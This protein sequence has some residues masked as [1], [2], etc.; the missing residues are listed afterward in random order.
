MKT[1]DT[2]GSADCCDASARNDRA[3]AAPG[4]AQNAVAQISTEEFPADAAA[5]RSAG[6][7]LLFATG[8]PVP[9]AALAAEAGIA[10]TDLDA[11]L[12]SVRDRGR[13]EIDEQ[14]CLVGIGGL[15]LI[16]G[17]HRF[18]VNGVSHWTW[19]ALDVVG[20]LGALGASGSVHST[21]P[22]SGSPINIEYVDGQPSADAHLFIPAG[23]QDANV[24]R[25]WCPNVNFFSSHQGAESWAAAQG[26]DGD[27]VA[28]SNILDDAVVMWNPVVAPQGSDQ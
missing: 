9:P 26:L 11:A 10:E 18:V 2:T 17:R 14:G 16:P 6:F 28:V 19:C 12:L 15:T 23:F 20:I 24:R 25:D 5:V 21:D 3:A 8:E 27:V 13:I 7:R 4:S 1:V 22:Y